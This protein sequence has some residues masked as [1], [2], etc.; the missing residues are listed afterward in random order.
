MNSITQFRRV[1]LDQHHTRFAGISV[2]RLSS[3]QGGLA[4]VCKRV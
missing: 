1:V 3:R 2:A 4:P